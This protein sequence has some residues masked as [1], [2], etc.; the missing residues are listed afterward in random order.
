MPTFTD[1]SLSAAG[2]GA[3]LWAGRAT[4]A[5]H[6]TVT[7]MRAGLASVY[8]HLGALAAVAGVL[9]LGSGSGSD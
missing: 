9:G 5:T 2:T 7:T 8:A 6:V 4:G 3:L 1:A